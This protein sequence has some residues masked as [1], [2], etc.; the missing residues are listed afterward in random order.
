MKIKFLFPV[1]AGVVGVAAIAGSSSSEEYEA[2][3]ESPLVQQ[4]GA[5][6]SVTL[7]GADGSL[8][9]AKVV[10][11]KGKLL[12]RFNGTSLTN[13]FEGNAVSVRRG[14]IP[15]IEGS[16]KVRTREGDCIVTLDNPRSFP[17]N[18]IQTA[19]A[20]PLLALN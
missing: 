2:I 20:E 15:V 11:R 13:E 10:T 6:C 1:L 14:E 9:S 7:N 19:S 4:K 12:W 17:I 5:Y 18:N 3:P 8:Y 16:F